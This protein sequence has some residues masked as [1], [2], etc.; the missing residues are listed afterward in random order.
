MDEGH[1]AELRSNCMKRVPTALVTGFFGAAS[2]V[3]SR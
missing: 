2:D 3:R 1:S